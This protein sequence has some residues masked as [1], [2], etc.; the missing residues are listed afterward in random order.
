MKRLCLVA[1]LALLLIVPIVQA[2]TATAYTVG[3]GAVVSL[4]TG[5]KSVSI[6]NMGPYMIF[7]GGATVTSDSGLPVPSGTSYNPAGSLVALEVIYAISVGGDSDVRVLTL[8]G[9]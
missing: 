8:N 7:L 5:V 2:A 4:A 6:H 3:P 9:L 1:V